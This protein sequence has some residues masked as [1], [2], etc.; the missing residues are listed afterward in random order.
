V[1]QQGLLLSF[2][3]YFAPNNYYSK[4]GIP[5]ILERRAANPSSTT[6]SLSDTVEYIPR[7]RI[8][9]SSQFHLFFWEWI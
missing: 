5:M 8:H 9:T 2:Y 7:I 3:P 1:G 4:I 6:P